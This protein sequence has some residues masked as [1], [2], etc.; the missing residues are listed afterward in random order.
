LINFDL[1]FFSFISCNYNCNC[2]CNYIKGQK[3]RIA[4]AR[5][6]LKQ[7]EI[8]LLDEATSALDNESESI[9][10]DALDKLMENNERT[11]IVI[12]VSNTHVNALG[13]SATSPDVM[14]VLLILYC[15][16]FLLVSCIDIICIPKAPVANY[17]ACG[18]DCIYW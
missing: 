1:F 8:L 12:A 2:N 5:A 15:C 14:I 6:I 7:P 10:Q 3:Q 16:S 4:I 17:P 9:V 11:C 13:V 18:S